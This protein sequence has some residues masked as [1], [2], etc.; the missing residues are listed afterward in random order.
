MRFLE[1]RW[2]SSAWMPRCTSKTTERSVG[3]GVSLRPRQES[4]PPSSRL[5]RSPGDAL[6][7]PRRSAE[8]LVGDRSPARR[9]SPSWRISRS[10]A[11]GPWTKPPELLVLFVSPSRSPTSISARRTQIR[12]VSGAMPSSRASS[13][14]G[15]PLSRTSRTALRWI[16]RMGSRQILL[17]GL[18]P[19]SVRVSTKPG[20]PQVGYR[21]GHGENAGQAE[22]P[23]LP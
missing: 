12:S 1:T 4:S 11:R 17:S 2:R 18:S 13:A 7:S 19:V 6:P 8:S 21:A 15:R 10:S 14:V 20:Q 16:W 23:R 5:A 9:K 3:A 22:V